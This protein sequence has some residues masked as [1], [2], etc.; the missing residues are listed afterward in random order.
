[1]ASNLYLTG[2]KPK[3]TFR[4]SKSGCRFGSSLS[5]L[6]R[7]GA[8]FG[9]DQVRIDSRDLLGSPRPAQPLFAECCFELARSG[10]RPKLITK[11]T[12][13]EVTQ[14]QK[15]RETSRL[16]DFH[17]DREDPVRAVSL[18]VLA[19]AGLGLVVG[20]L[21]FDSVFGYVVAALGI[22]GI[23]AL[24]VG[25][26]SKA[27]ELALLVGGGF[28]PV[29]VVAALFDQAKPTFV[30]PVLVA[31]S[32]VAAGIAAGY[33]RPDRVW[34]SLLVTWAVIP[35][36]LLLSIGAFVDSPEYFLQNLVFL[37]VGVVGPLALTLLGGVVGRFIAS[38]EPEREVTGVSRGHVIAI[39]RVFVLGLALLLLAFSPVYAVNHTVFRAPAFEV[40]LLDDGRVELSQATV[41]DGPF[42]IPYRVTNAASEPR[43]LTFRGAQFDTGLGGHGPNEPSRMLQPG[44]SIDAVMA[45]SGGTGP[46]QI[47]LCNAPNGD[48]VVLTIE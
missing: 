33:W 31:M 24:L 40:T 42:G 3:S 6:H 39:A 8:G 12:V 18:A 1:M 21:K 34:V 2:R 41:Q 15:T 13:A 10:N 29:L 46:G 25:F 23:L 28:I 17:L 36:V 44:E 14:V 26:F 7:G 9:K 47:E 5:S 22:A 35:I 30:P 16:F 48:C 20:A 45:I 32:F 27:A 4:R 43:Q 19:I 37:V 38:R 11:V